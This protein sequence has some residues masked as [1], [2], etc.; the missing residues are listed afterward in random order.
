MSGLLEKYHICYIVALGRE[1]YRNNDVQ[2]STVCTYVRSDIVLIP[3]TFYSKIPIYSCSNM[4]GLLEK[5]HI[6]YISSSCERV[7]P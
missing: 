5:Y 4:S 2:K 7:V 6:C 3:K 1:L